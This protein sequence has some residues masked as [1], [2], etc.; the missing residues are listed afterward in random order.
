[1]LSATGRAFAAVAWLCCCAPERALALPLSR[2]IL[3]EGFTITVFADSVPG[4]RSLTRGAQGTIFV[5]SRTP[6]H[7]Y[8]LRDTNDDGVCDS[9]YRVAKGLNMPNGVAMQGADLVVAE[10]H[11]L[12]VF[13][14][15]EAHLASPPPYRVLRDDLPT[16]AHHG[17]K[18]I[19]QGPDGHLY[20]PVGAPCNVCQRDDPRYASILRLDPAGEAWEVYATGVRNTVGFDWHPVTGELWFTDNG[21]DHLGDDAPP[22]ELNRAVRSGLHF[23]FPHC[24]GRTVVDPEYGL[25]TG[26]DGFVPPRLE[27]GA[28]VAALGMRFYTGRMFPAEY[29][30]SV[31][32]AEHGSWNRSSPVGYQVSVVRIDDSTVTD[33]KPF[34]TGWLSPEGIWGRPVDVLCLPDGSLLISD[35]YANA[36]YRVSW[37]APNRQR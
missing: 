16:D 25:S 12:L 30:G 3:P 9:V 22:D 17:W 29:H 5:G 19:A 13:P 11:R 4:A 32:L 23:G 20:V 24:H 1:M 14:D 7:V 10:I 15:L 26:C 6:G 27:L 28:H 35:D 34:V 33:Y 37:V 18:F 8:A 31:F 2:L 21:R 36:I